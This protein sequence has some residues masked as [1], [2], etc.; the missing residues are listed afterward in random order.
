MLAANPLRMIVEG[1][2]EGILE[3]EVLRVDANNP[4]TGAVSLITGE[5]VMDDV[6][7]K[8]FKATIDPLG[9][10][11]EGEHPHYFKQKVCNVPTYSIYCRLNKE[12]FRAD[13]ALPA[14]WEDNKVLD[15]TGGG[16]FSGKP[17][18]Y[19]SPGY[20]ETG[21][22]LTFERRAI[23]ADAPIAG[24][25]R[26]TIENPLRKAADGQAVKVYPICNRS[27]QDCDVR[28]GNSLNHKAQ[29][30]APRDN[31]SADIPSTQNAA[32]GKKG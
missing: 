25:W 16:P 23:L 6:D 24:G 29:P 11:L 31:P 2:L 10:V 12:D 30:W 32:G 26:L 21:T 3:C 7:G 19:F 20:F 13:G 28:F 9:G 22:G 8:D 1:T 4:E 14:N 17:A 5:V 27:I 15:V 18:D